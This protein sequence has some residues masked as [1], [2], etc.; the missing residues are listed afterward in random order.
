MLGIAT[1]VLTSVGRERTAAL[2]TFGAVVAV[3][4]SCALAVP[5]AEFG[6][7]Q[8][9]RSTQASGGAL[10]ASLIVAGTIVHRNAGAF[11]RAATIARVGLALGACVALGFVLPRVGRLATPAV[12]AFVGLGYVGLLLALREIGAADL[13]MVRALRR[14]R[15]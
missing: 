8:L 7:T 3:G 14:K 9:L 15:G 5:H 12:A 13:A 6:H 4:A 11:V 2:V 1:T 10:L